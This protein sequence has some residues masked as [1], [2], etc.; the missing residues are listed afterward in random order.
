[1]LRTTLF[2]M[3]MMSVYLHA[4]TVQPSRSAALSEYSGVYWDEVYDEAGSGY[5][6][7]DTYW[8]T[9]TDTAYVESQEGYKI[10]STGPLTVRKQEFDTGGCGSSCCMRWDFWTYSSGSECPTDYVLYGN[11]CVYEPLDTDGDGIPDSTDTDDDGD[12]IPD[13]ED[14]NPLIPDSTGNDFGSGTDESCRGMD[15]NSVQFHGVQYP[16]SSDY[17]YI[18]YTYEA[19]ECASLVG[20]VYDGTFELSDLDPTNCFHTYCYGHKIVPDCSNPDVASLTPSGGY[21]YKPNLSSL[22]CSSLENDP[23][24]SDSQYVYPSGCP[25]DGLCFVLPDSE[26]SSDSPDAETTNPEV[27][28]DSSQAMKDLEPLL[29]AQNNTTDSLNALGDKADKTNEHLSSLLDKADSLQV[30]NDRIARAVE[31]MDIDGLN[32]SIT[33]AVDAGTS[34]TAQ[35]IDKV[36]QQT[37]LEANG[38]NG[39]AD[40]MDELFKGDIDDDEVTDGLEGLSEYETTVNDA[41]NTFWIADPLGIG[42]GYSSFQIDPTVISVRGEQ[43]VLFDQSSL[44][45]L[46]VEA[47]RALMLLIA[48]LA[49]SI[50]FF[51]NV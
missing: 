20:S 45:K 40:K 49:G 31:S 47:L 11:S 32:R 33:S 5:L 15:V 26:Y 7:A 16:H 43:Y 10:M 21:V 12:G 42:T 13:T 51:R 37:N 29:D 22:S 34:L 23:R 44:D 35:L 25:S 3:V 36:E 1:M 24:Y 4:Y 6:P 39:L 9:T 48:A 38:F 19:V 41:F 30:S 28:E 18:K 27:D 50:N 2:L 8:C 17:S 46:P 14:E